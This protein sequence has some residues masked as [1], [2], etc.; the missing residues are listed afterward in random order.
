MLGLIR[1]PGV[2]E[3]IIVAAVLIYFGFRAFA[4]KWPSREAE[5]YRNWVVAAATIAAFVALIMALVL[6]VQSA[7]EG[8]DPNTQDAIDQSDGPA[9]DVNEEDLQPEKDEDEGPIGQENG[10]LTSEEGNTPG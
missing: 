4:R 7:P 5:I 2:I 1:T 9:V 8:N 3:L 10:T 6:I